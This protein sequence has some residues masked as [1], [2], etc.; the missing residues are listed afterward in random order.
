[1]K[2]IEPSYR[3]T[4]MDTPKKYMSTSKPLVRC[5]TRPP[6]KP[7]VQRHLYEDWYKES[8]CLLLSMQACLLEMREKLPA[9]FEGVH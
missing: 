7:P 6:P 9:I 8:T 2:I 4:K 3:I 5:V 1:M